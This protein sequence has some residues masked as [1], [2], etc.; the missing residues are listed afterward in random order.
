[1]IIKQPSPGIKLLQTAALYRRTAKYFP[2]WPVI[3]D[4]FGRLKA[5]Y[6]GE[7]SL[8]YELN[9]LPKNSHTSLFDIRLTNNQNYFFQTDVCFITKSFALIM[10]VK[11][12]SGKVYFDLY[13]QMIRYK[14]DGTEEC[15]PDPINQ[16]MIQE[17]HFRKWL[18]QMKWTLPVE[19]IVVFTNPQTIITFSDTYNPSLRLKVIRKRILPLKI[20]DL[21]KKYKSE[22][23]TDKELKKLTYQLLKFHT[24]PS[25]NALEHY[26]LKSTDILSG[27]QCPICLHLPMRRTFG[28][29]FCEHCCCFNAT[30]HKAAFQDYGLL[31]DAHITNRQAKELLHLESA[32]ITKRL[33]KEMQYPIEGKGNSIK[34]KIKQ[35]SDFSI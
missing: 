12:I 11:N 21:S 26:K 35:Q 18:E 2:Q 28:K 32:S 10:E 17:S 29:W 16:V 15:F 8:L 5:G 24:E 34:Y 19:S 27:V 22:L 9:M 23:L 7:V 1:M 14:K 6:K 25:P 4:D 33:L 13:D 3:E 20:Q 31:I 30:A